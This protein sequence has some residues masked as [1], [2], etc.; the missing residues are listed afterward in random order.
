MS[1]N[2]K[3]P[4]VEQ[5]L[6][7]MTED[8]GTTPEAMKILSEI[9]PSMVLEHA[10]SRRFANEENS[11]PEKYRQL[12]TIAAVAGS[13]APSCIKTQIDVALHQGID[14]IEI[15]DALVVARFA[16]A[17][18]VFSNSVEGLRSLVDWAAGSE[19]KHV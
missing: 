5:V 7:K 15:V 18:T 16:L 6:A 13:G 10:R 11:I 2:P 12:I 17:S 19:E 9:K 14:P 8:V 4:T 1:D 3:I